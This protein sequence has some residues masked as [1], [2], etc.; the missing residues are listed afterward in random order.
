LKIPDETIRQ[1]FV[2]G[3]FRQMHILKVKF[4]TIIPTNNNNMR[5][6]FSLV[7]FLFIIATILGSCKNESVEPCDSNSCQ[8][9]GV[10]VDGICVCELGYLGAD[11]STFD[12]SYVQRL[13]DV[14]VPPIEIFEQD[15]P[16]DS[17][18]GKVYL[19]GFIFY[20]DTTDGSGLV[21]AT[22]DQS[23]AAEWG[24]YDV[25]VSG[26][27]NVF[28]FPS[29]PETEQGA[30]IGDG[31]VNTDA[32]LAEMCTNSSGTDVYA[33]KLCRDLGPDWFL[34]SREELFLI[35]TNLVMNNL[36]NFEAKN[37][38]SSTEADSLLAWMTRLVN[39]NQGFADKE[40]PGHVR[41][42]RSY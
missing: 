30:R 15:I 29:E 35:Q 20:L 16:L 37:Y 39:L 21:V 2:K 25:D 36:G 6:A 9:N 1:A 27:T 41:A 12:P 23:D 26:A 5:P 19:D 8:N 22:S 7:L 18:Y 13:L 24:C 40:L 17:L 14:G 42:V 4:Q 28:D 31:N 3:F 33:A 34:P 11:C 38:W 10:C 32:I